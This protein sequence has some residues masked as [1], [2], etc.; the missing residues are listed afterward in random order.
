MCQ[1]DFPKFWIKQLEKHIEQ[2]QYQVKSCKFHDIVWIDESGGS[3]LSSLHVFLW[4]LLVFTDFWRSGALFLAMCCVLE[5]KHAICCI[6]KLKSFMY[7]FHHVVCGFHWFL[8]GVHWFFHSVH[9]FYMVFIVFP[10]FSFIF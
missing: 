6:L 8:H 2:S 5:L 3:H 4:F 1:I 7:V 9:C 10:L